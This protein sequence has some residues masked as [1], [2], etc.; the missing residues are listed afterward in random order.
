MTYM[1]HVSRAHKVLK[2]GG[3]ERVWR[4]DSVIPYA[5][6]VVVEVHLLNPTLEDDKGPRD[7]SE[8]YSLLTTEKVFSVKVVDVFG[9]TFLGP[10]LQHLSLCLTHGNS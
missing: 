10:F 1:V 6:T 3:E 8:P 2:S 5:V 7:C 4:Q 9:A